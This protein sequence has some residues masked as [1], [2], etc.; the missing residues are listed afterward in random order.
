[1]MAR[2]GMTCKLKNHLR[3]LLLFF[4]EK[5]QPHIRQQGY[6]QYRLINLRSERPVS[7]QGHYQPR[8]YSWTR[9][10]SMQLENGLRVN[11]FEL[12]KMTIH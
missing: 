8:L 5:L 1:M 11:V 3:F 12:R 7:K 2:I 10:L 6:L 4:V 9:L